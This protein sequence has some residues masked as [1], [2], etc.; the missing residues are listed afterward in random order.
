MTKSQSVTG[1]YDNFFAN[2][3]GAQ[4]GGKPSNELLATAF[5]LGCKKHGK[6]SLANAM[7]LRPNGVTGGEIVIAC[8]APQLNKMRGFIAD[9]LVARIPMADRNGQG[10]YKLELTDK[11]KAKVA[12]AVTDK[13]ADKRPAKVSAK[14]ATKAKRKAK[15]KAKLV[16][17]ENEQAKPSI[18]E[19][20]KAEV[21]ESLK[22]M[23]DTALG[24][25]HTDNAT[26]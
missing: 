23:A 25:G 24:V 9:K 18:A 12:A 16:E 5:N 8:G 17:P 14:S 20:F 22:A 13:P 19:T 6:Q 2:W 4:V 21:T 10:V 1:W 26:N 7:A 11:G 3:P 15:V